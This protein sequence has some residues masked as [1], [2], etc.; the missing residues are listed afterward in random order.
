MRRL[1][2]IC[3]LL[4]LAACGGPSRRMV[5]Q[6][7]PPELRVGVQ[8]HVSR[9]AVSSDSPF[10][11]SD[12]KGVLWAGDGEP[13]QFEL[14]PN[15]RIR[16]IQHGERIAEGKGPYWVRPDNHAHIIRVGGKSYPG[17]VELRRSGERGMNA[18]NI[19]DAEDYLR[20]VIPGEIAH[21]G[22]YGQ[23]A[24]AQAVAART[25]ALANL[26]KYPEEGFDLYAGVQDQ[27]YGPV[28][29]RHPEAD[30]AVWETRGQVLTY[31]S[32]LIEAKYASTCGGKVAAYEESFDA[33]APYLK[34]LTDK[35]DG[36]DA[37]RAS[38]YY[39]WEVR[40][41]GE[42]LRGILGKTLPSITGEALNGAHIKE[43]RVEER[44]PSKRVTKLRIE[45]DRQTYFVEKGDIRR[46]LL[47]ED[48]GMLRSTAFEIKTTKKN[49]RVVEIELRGRGWGHGVGMCQWGAMQ[50]STEGH[51]YNGILNHYYP[52][53][54]L[55]DLY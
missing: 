36:K 28:E 49:G 32:T 50:L 26:G 10:T 23:A 3:L 48:G 14:T 21:A 18:V 1:A 5:T 15:N 11:L 54:D 25:Y 4:A 12:K 53:A 35:V 41:S 17:Y 42:T 46:L 40:Y 44:G 9:T 6:E 22:P 24:R 39:R 43:I 20:A 16:V 45:T 30:E 52:K 19:V 51:S 37:C 13:L 29:K 34:S 47:R 7:G 2:A 38:R 8:V 55:E 31:D 27:V 33:E